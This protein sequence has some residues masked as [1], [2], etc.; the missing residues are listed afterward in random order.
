MALESITLGTDNMAEYM[1][2]MPMMATVTQ[3]FKPTVML[4]IYQ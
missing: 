1:G 2:A 3:M 4:E